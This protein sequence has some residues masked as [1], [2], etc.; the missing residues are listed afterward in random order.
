MAMLVSDP[1]ILQT[2]TRFT[3]PQTDIRGVYDPH[4]MGWTARSKLPPSDFWFLN[5]HRF[6][7]APSHKYDPNVPA[8]FMHNKT[9]IID[10]RLVITSSYNFSEHAED[11]DENLLV[12]DSQAV[13]AAYT[14]YFDTLF[15][16][17]SQTHPAVYHH[18]QAAYH[19]QQAAMHHLQAA[20]AH[21]TGRYKDAAQHAMHAHAHHLQATDHMQQSARKTLMHHQQ[22]TEN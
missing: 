1:G 14:Q 7:A 20:E 21:R 5:D 11:N 13:A 10:D 22:S 16:V 19:Y 15:A 17:Y 4:E 9:L 8:D 2:L 6:V 18:E 3:N 12:L